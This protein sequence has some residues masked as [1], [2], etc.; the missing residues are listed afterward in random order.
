MQKPDIMRATNSLADNETMDNAAK[1]AAMRLRHS[2]MLSMRAKRTNKLFPQ[3]TPLDRLAGGVP[4]QDSQPYINRHGRIDID[5]WHAGQLC[6]KDCLHEGNKRHMTM[7]PRQ[8]SAD[9][10]R[11]AR[12]AT[13]RPRAGV[14]SRKSVSV[15]SHYARVVPCIAFAY[16][17]L[18]VMVTDGGRTS[19]GFISNWQRPCSVQRPRKLPRRCRCNWLGKRQTSGSKPPSRRGK[20]SRH[21]RC[22]QLQMSPSCH[23]AHDFARTAPQD[24]GWFAPHTWEVKKVGTAIAA[25]GTAGM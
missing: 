1:V 15:R 18:V 10:A 24:G 25:C 6:Y 19:H 9:P 5:A 13:P 16:E 12:L 23:Q 7:T 22:C 3:H 4:S 2:S 21:W 17:A 11:I 14:E 20:T 8:T